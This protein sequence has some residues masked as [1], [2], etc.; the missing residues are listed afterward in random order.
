M[1]Y[2][3]GRAHEG[4]WSSNQSFRH[5]RERP[6][7]TDGLLV[8]SMGDQ[9]SAPPCRGPKGLSSRQRQERRWRSQTRRKRYGHSDMWK[10]EDLTPQSSYVSDADLRPFEPSRVAFS[11]SLFLR[12][13]LA[14]CLSSQD[15]IP[16]RMS[17]PSSRVKMLS[18]SLPFRPQRGHAST[19]QSHIH[20]QY[21]PLQMS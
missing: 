16:T 19:H 3:Y 15:T 11:S 18:I 7:S 10:T 9:H 21:R 1:L 2:S 17:T 14:P 4:R 6:V 12:P 5:K 8:V 13:P 20:Q